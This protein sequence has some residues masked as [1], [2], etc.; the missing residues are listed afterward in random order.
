M[1]K[2]NIFRIQFNYLPDYQERV[3]I[4]AALRLCG[5]YVQDFI[6]LFNRNILL[7]KLTAEQ[8]ETFINK[9]SQTQYWNNCN[10]L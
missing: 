5:A 10:V 3:Q 8:Y 4:E 7:Y 1:S 6:Y 9:F 2:P